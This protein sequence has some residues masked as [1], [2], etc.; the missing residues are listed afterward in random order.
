MTPLAPGWIQ[1]TGVPGPVVAGTGDP[2]QLPRWSREVLG[3]EHAGAPADPLAAQV[4]ALRRAR[5]MDWADI[6]HEPYGWVLELGFVW[7]A[8]DPWALSWTEAAANPDDAQLQL[9]MR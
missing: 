2:R 4:P 6:R 3:R 1:V 9:L 8:F 5:R 7:D